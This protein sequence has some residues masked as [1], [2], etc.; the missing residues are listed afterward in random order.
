MLYFLNYATRVLSVLILLSPVNSCA[1]EEIQGLH[2]AATGNNEFECA[3]KAN[4][5]GMRRALVLVADR[6]G[7]KKSNF[8]NVPYP[9]LR[10]AFTTIDKISET[11]FDEKYSADVSY[12]YDDLVTNNLILKYGSPEVQEQFFEYIIIPVFKQKNIITFLDSKTEW[13][14]T[15]IDSKE[16]CSRYRLLPIDPTKMSTNIT[17][18]NIFSMS[19]ADF[20]HTL[21]IKRFKNILIASCE[22]FTNPDGSMYFSVTTQ[23]ISQFAK[24]VTETKYDI[25]NPAAAKKYFDIAIERIIDKF[26]KRTRSDMRVQNITDVTF[27]SERS[28]L[29][30]TNGNKKAGSVLDELLVQPK[31]GKPLTKVQMRADIFSKE[32]LASFKEK[33]SKVTAVVKYKINIDDADHYV[34]ELYTNKTMQELS[35]EFYLNNLSYRLYN[36]EY[37]VFELETGI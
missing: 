16:E 30:S 14:A 12:G 24:N 3:I 21:K 28:T 6:I 32:G 19:Y 20:L 37:V 17:T 36:A 8:G 27:E 7:I 13:L 29:Q 1:L 25:G 10:K 2:I 9:E 23:E 31:R 15:W 33:L 18:D 4:I 34:V 11:I 22:Y 5:E 26:G 35:E